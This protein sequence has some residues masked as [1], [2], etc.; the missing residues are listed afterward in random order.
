MIRASLRGAKLSMTHARKK[1]TCTHC[2]EVL[3]VSDALSSVEFAWPEWQ[4]VWCACPFCAEGNHIRFS[5]NG[6]QRLEV[7]GHGDW[8]ADQEIAVE[9][10]QIRVDPELLH[11]WRLDKH[12]EFKARQ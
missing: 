4:T 7:R 12:Y 5:E 10:L 3:E 6:A 1:L 9:N 11:V 8:E 2:N